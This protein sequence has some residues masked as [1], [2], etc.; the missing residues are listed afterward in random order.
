M[1]DQI[2]VWWEKIRTALWPLPLVMLVLSVGLYFMGLRVDATLSNSDALRSWLLH[3]G[4]GED[5]RNLLSTLVTAIITMSSVVFSIT[6]VALSLAANQFGSRLLRTYM[7]EWR[8]Q[9][10]LGLFLMTV[11]Y[12]LLA[13]RSVS[14]DMEPDQVPHL[15]VSF[16]LALGAICVV[17][18][19]FFLHLVAKS[20]IAD[21]V[22][23]RVARELEQNIRSLA[24]LEPG[25][26]RAAIPEVPLPQDFEERS[27]IVHSREEGYVQAVEYERLVRLASE[28]GFILRLSFDAGAFMCRDGW[29]AHIHPGRVLTPAIGRE[30]HKAILI[31]T[32]RT[33]TQDVEFSIRHLVDVALRA[34]SPGINDA[35]TA[36][37]VI[38]HL[39]GALSSLM[40]RSLPTAVHRDDAGTIRVVGTYPGYNDVIDAAL[41]Q[42]RHSAASHPSVVI[43]LLDALGRIAEHVR[44]PA[45]RDSLLRHSRLIFEAGLR[46]P[47]EEHDRANIQSAFAAT[48]R[49]LEVAPYAY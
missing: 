4:N 38:D 29:L 23:S 17:A 24:P 20:L 39:R 10:S 49:K 36:L 1:T 14:G 28:H 9:L 44:L 3:S 48:V 26:A 30:I 16:G 19:I 12:C 25:K 7:A 6:I 11:I 34:L 46:E 8:T 31:G 15:T 35:N 2:F 22:I 40:G 47:G 18:L 42:I 33:P 21:E 45:Q 32:M 43:S 5:A 27:A 41:S 13:L 37:V